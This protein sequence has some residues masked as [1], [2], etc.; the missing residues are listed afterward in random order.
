MNLEEFIR[1]FCTT[2][3]GEDDAAY[4]KGLT[5]LDTHDV[6]A[7]VPESF[8][9]RADWADGLYRRVWVSE[10]DRAIITYCE[11]DITVGQFDGGEAFKKQLA[12]AR[13]FYEGQD[14]P[15]VSLQ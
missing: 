4:S 8:R 1:A 3:Q 6:A 2:R 9:E 15:I 14:S 11:G 12:H 10:S 5:L 7:A 13:Q